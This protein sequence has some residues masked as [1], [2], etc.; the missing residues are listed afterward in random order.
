MILSCPKSMEETT[1]ELYFGRL[2]SAAV[3]RFQ[4]HLRD[5]P[6][7]RGI[8]DGTVAMI[9]AIR[10]AANILSEQRSPKVKASFDPPW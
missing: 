10:G 8:N 2:D 6:K 9:E 4:A 3:Q 5:C 1:E 7:C